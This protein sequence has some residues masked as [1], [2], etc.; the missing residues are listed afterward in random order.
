MHTDSQ[1]ANNFSLPSIPALD[2]LK[3]LRQWVAWKYENRG[4][5]KPTKTP[6]N[7]H[8]GTYASTANPATWGS[9][10]QA[11]RRAQSDKLPGTGYCL[12]EDDNITGDD[13]DG[14]FNPKTGHTKP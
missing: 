9:Y 2:E 14:V 4:G 1:I 13:L 3:S 11:A 5:K 8:T 12:S 10:E 7:P 6:I